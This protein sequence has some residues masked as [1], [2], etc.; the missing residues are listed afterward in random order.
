MALWN[1]SGKV[2]LGWPIEIPKVR[3]CCTIKTFRGDSHQHIFIRLSWPI[4]IS[5]VR[6]GWPTIL[7]LKVCLN[8]LAEC[9]QVQL[10][11]YGTMEFLRQS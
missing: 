2:R 3:L 7:F 9:I 8:K 10:I 1:F 5:K 11:N 6:L 4:K